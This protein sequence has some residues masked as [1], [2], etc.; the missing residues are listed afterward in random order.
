[1][2]EK[3]FVKT[4]GQLDAILVE[5]TAKAMLDRTRAKRTDQFISQQ[6]SD[7]FNI[8]KK[9]NTKIEL[10][11]KFKIMEEEAHLEENDQDFEDDVIS[12]DNYTSKSNESYFENEK[13]LNE[14]E[15][16]FILFFPLLLSIKI[17]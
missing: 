6:Y 4:R 8:S 15:V 3:P 13:N 1:M 12:E 2:P 17:N 16:T 5:W 9:K 10:D 11:T 7:G 14:S